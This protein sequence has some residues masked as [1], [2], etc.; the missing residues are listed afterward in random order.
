MGNKRLLWMADFMGSLYGDKDSKFK[1]GFAPKFADQ[2][3]LLI[4]RWE[5]WYKNR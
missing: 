3:G 5:N 4:G 2:M 1:G